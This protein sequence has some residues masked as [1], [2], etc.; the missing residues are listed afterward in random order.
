MQVLP[1]IG[2][3]LACMIY[4]NSNEKREPSMR[5]QTWIYNMAKEY[6]ITKS[7]EWRNF[8]S[9]FLIFLVF[10]V[11]G[12]LMFYYRS[13]EED[14]WNFAPFLAVGFL[15]FFVPQLV[16]HLKYYSL[17]DGL[18]MFYNNVE[19]KITIKDEKGKVESSFFLEDIKV[20]FHT[21][22]ASMAERRMQWFPWDNYN[23][24]IIYLSNG[25]KYIITSLMV[26][27]LE[28]PVGNKYE[29]MTSFYPYPK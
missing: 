15:C 10:M 25:K 20:V 28:L 18:V 23:Y 2:L 14:F 19:K 8:R 4:R 9:I 5:F 1:V 17:N 29:V 6:K 24:S 21:M 11:V 3:Q 12:P 13:P 26:Y 16:I 7:N 27:R 22:T